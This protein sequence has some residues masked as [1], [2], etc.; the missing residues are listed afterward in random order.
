M[1][2]DGR[3]VSGSDGTVEM[4]EQ[5]GAEASFMPRGLVDLSSLITSPQPS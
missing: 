1:D 3:P 5:G 2:D 4:E